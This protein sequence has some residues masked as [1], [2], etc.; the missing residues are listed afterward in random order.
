MGDCCSVIGS[1]SKPF[2]S[3][4]FSPPCLRASVVN[5]VFSV[6]SYRDFMSDGVGFGPGAIATW[7]GPA[8]PA[9]VHAVM[10]P[11]GCG[12]T[13]YEADAECAYPASFRFPAALAELPGIY[14]G[15]A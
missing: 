9:A 14:G 5:C 10:D 12:T 6:H 13:D 7:D 4:Y 1:C 2:P 8:D 3:L 11:V 15:Q